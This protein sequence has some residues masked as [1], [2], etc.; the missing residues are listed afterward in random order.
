[1]TEE[2]AFQI[3]S[4]WYERCLESGIEPEAIVAMMGGM[5]LVTDPESA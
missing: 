5:T 2:E 4:D 1:M 3:F